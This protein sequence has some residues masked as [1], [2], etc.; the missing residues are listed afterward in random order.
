MRRVLLGL[1]I[2]ALAYPALLLLSGGEFSIGA[3]L[4]VG[5]FT[6]GATV[7]VGLPL[8][9]WFFRR[10]WVKWWQFLLGGAVCG[11][12]AAFPFAVAGLVPLAAVG[13]AF[14]LVGAGHGLAFWFIAVFR[15][16][17]LPLGHP[18]FGG[19]RDAT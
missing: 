11:A 2:C 9:G 6:V 4:W 3:A 8:L 5:M 17:R 19:P 1:L 15:N 18:L 13:A 7:L 10:R 12:V 16:T 14:V